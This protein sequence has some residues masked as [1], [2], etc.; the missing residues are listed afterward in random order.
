M[1]L[2]M[3]IGALAIGAEFIR[4]AAPV[5]RAMGAIADRCCRIFYRAAYRAMRL[6]WFVRRP[7][8]RGALVAL[9]HD[10]EILMVRTSYRRGW[11][12]P[13]GSVRRGESALDAARREIRE[14]IGLA[15]PAAAL[16]AVQAVEILLDYRHDH[17]TIFE[18]TADERPLP[19]PDN[20]EIVAAIFRRPA[21][22]A[23]SE[24]N[25]HV[26]RYLAQRR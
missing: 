16:R 22:I 23:A 1:S 9:W 17:V 18:M 12:L 8:H 2:A 13:G 5:N 20:R 7:R 11:D 14:E 25:P 15:I 3:R 6:W 4:P 10:G 21:S 19:S 24:V 26:A